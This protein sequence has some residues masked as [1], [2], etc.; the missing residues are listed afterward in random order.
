[1]A[2]PMP[3]LLS[4]LSANTAFTLAQYKKSDTSPSRPTISSLYLQHL[5]TPKPAHPPKS[6]GLG[7]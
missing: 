4:L 5:P 6:K 1:M 2:V 7:N 3:R